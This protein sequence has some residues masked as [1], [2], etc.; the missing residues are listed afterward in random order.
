VQQA[1]INPFVRTFVHVVSP[2]SLIGIMN[3]I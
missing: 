1:H 3:S 2:P